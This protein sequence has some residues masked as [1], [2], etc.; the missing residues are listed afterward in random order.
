V[1]IVFQSKTAGVVAVV[2]GIEV[3]SLL[4]K[5]HRILNVMG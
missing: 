1:D 3:S 2:S 5:S 4:K